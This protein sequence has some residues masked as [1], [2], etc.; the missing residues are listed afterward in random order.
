M[1]TCGHTVLSACRCV[2][3]EPI[4]P[5]AM[6]TMKRSLQELLHCSQGEDANPCTPTS[7]RGPKAE[8]QRLRHLLQVTASQHDGF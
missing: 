5:A 6:N 3:A 2:S 7:C 8:S 1:D 4:T